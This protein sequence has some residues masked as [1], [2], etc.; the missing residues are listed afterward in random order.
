MA[1]VWVVDCRK[2]STACDLKTPQPHTLF[3]QQ[4]TSEVDSRSVMFAWV[5]HRMSHAMLLLCTAVCQR[6]KIFLHWQCMRAVHVAPALAGPPN[7]IHLSHTFVARLCRISRLQPSVSTGKLIKRVLQEPVVFKGCSFA[8]SCWDMTRYDRPARYTFYTYQGLLGF[9][10]I[11]KEHISQECL[12]CPDA[13]C[14]VECSAFA[15]VLFAEHL[16]KESR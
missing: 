7:L 3:L 11:H 8:S 14:Y 16:G 13:A 6:G 10:H 4:K 9:L 2:I 15:E 12:Y 5:E 1:Q